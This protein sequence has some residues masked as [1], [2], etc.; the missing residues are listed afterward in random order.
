MLLLTNL[1]TQI[2]N[3]YINTTRKN[4]FNNDLF[5]HYPGLKSFPSCLMIL[6]TY[7]FHRKHTT[8]QDRLNVR[9]RQF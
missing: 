5:L 2:N 1:N 7:R 6:L 4:G 9:R 3:C 8:L